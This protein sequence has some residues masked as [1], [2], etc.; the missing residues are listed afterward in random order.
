[1]R[2][3]RALTYRGGIEGDLEGQ[4]ELNKEFVIPPQTSI[5]D[6]GAADGT[7]LSDSRFTGRD[8]SA[9]R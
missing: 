1:M 2:A 4:S 9:H 5:N 7:S 8:G 3:Y 6:V